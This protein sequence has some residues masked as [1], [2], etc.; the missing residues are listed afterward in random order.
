MKVIPTISVSSEN[1]Y[2]KVLQQ[3]NDESIN[4]FRINLTRFSLHEYY[5]EL[6]TIQKV[7]IDLWGEERIHPLLDVPFPGTKARVDFDGENASFPI[8][9]GEFLEVRKDGQKDFVNHKIAVDNF[10]DLAHA[11]IGD[12]I[13]I[14][15]GRLRLRVVEKEN[16]IVKMVAQNSGKIKWK[17]SINRVGKI[18]FEEN[19]AQYIEALFSLFGK[20]QPK[21]VVFSFLESKMQ[22]EAILKERNKR[23]LKFKIIPKIE[24]ESAVNN[25]NELVSFTDTVMIGRGDLALVAGPEKLGLLEEKILRCKNMFGFKVILATDVLNSLADLKMA[26]PLRSDLIDLDLAIKNGVEAITI[27]GGK[28]ASDELPDICKLVN[29]MW[30]M[31]ARE[32]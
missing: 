2:R 26:F 13:E 11:K 14:D 22:M 7:Q 9:A 5:H 21:A 16:S 27:S 12:R 18:Y 17:K 23:G 8:S 3:Y 15:D 24:T 31:R 20:V 19:R 10:S 1:K 29:S 30:E 25:L 4:F 32:N 28:D 6:I